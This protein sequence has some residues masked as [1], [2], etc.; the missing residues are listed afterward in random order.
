MAVPICYE[1]A[2]IMHAAL[3][4]VY[5]EQIPVKEIKCIAKE[6]SHCSFQAGITESLR[7]GYEHP[8]KA[9]PSMH[10]YFCF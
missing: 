4:A 10:G 9:S 1:F 5:K 6:D 8:V 2:G 7:R 3:S